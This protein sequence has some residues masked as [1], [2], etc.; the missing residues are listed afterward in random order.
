MF[1]K[2]KKINKYRNDNIRNESCELCMEREDVT[3]Y[4]YFFFYIFTI[5]KACALSMNSG[6]R[7]GKVQFCRRESKR[8]EKNMCYDMRACFEYVCR[9]K[10]RKSRF[11]CMF[12][13]SWKKKEKNSVFRI[14]D[15]KKF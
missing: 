11:V 4:I 8:R 2:I 12:K 5:S 6:K 1:N 9:C 15:R 14:Y 13:V 10:W 7:T 3:I